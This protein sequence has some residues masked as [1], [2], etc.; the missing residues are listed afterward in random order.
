MS[1]P[2]VLVSHHTV[3]EGMVDEFRQS[4]RDY[5]PVLEANKPRTVGFLHYYDEDER[6]V[7]TLHI[8]PDAEAM[9]HH[10]EGA[11]ER[12]GRAYQFLVPGRF[13]IYGKPNEKAM[14]FM[15][16]AAAGSGASLSVKP[17][18]VAGYLRLKSG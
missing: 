16:Q 7:T 6:E 10:V 14:E 9:E 8:F 17:E 5:T 12:A 1:E 3:K 13:E 4:Y 11:S 18:Y 15:K 2:I